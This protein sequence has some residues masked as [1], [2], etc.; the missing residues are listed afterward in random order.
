MLFCTFLYVLKSKLNIAHEELIY[1][2][3]DHNFAKVKFTP[4]SQRR[5][6]ILAIGNLLNLPGL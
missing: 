5:G 3:L 6:L 2:H 4:D 1:F